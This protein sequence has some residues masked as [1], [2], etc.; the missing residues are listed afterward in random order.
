MGMYQPATKEAFDWALSKPDMILA[1]GTEGRFLNDMA[2][3]KL[4]KSKG[5]MISSVECYIKEH[6]VT[7]E[8]ALEAFATMVDH[9]WKKINLALIELD[10]SIL[11]MAPVVVNL[12]RGNE[13][14]YHQG[15]DVYTFGSSLKETV[16]SLYLKDF[17]V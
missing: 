6:G 5:D 12:A 17:P 14:L 9:L 2:S 13:T 1:I 11:S 8:D 4:G 7:E 10:R 16:T 15:R 3:Y